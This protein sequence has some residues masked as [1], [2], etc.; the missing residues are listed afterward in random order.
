MQSPYTAPNRSSCDYRACDV[1]ILRTVDVDTARHVHFIT[2]KWL[3]F[4]AGLAVQI[5]TG[6]AGRGITVLGSL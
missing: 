4:A 5:L 2:A 3:N 1:F 6:S